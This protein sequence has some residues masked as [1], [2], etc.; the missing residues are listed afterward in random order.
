[1][2]GPASACVYRNTSRYRRRPP[3]IYVDW[4][5]E[6]VMDPTGRLLEFRNA[7]EKNRLIDRKSVV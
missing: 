1:M 2:V 7:N 5:N 6:N 4:L 3:R